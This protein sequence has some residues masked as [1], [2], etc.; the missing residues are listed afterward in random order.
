AAGP[1]GDDGD[2][3]VQAFGTAV[4]GHHGG[5]HAE[6]GPGTGPGGQVEGAF[7]RGG[8]PLPVAV[9]VQGPAGPHESHGCLPTAHRLSPFRSRGRGC[10]PTVPGTRDVKTAGGKRWGSPSAPLG[11]SARAPAR[12]SS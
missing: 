1:S 2:T 10:S 11:R 5:T 12:R 8:A 4:L 9:L 6:E 3:S 7:G